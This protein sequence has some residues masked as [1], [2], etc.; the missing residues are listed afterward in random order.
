MGYMQ[1]PRMASSPSE[2]GGLNSAVNNTLA[3]NLGQQY[4]PPEAERALPKL[5]G[6][7]RSP[8]QP[9]QL[10]GEMAAGSGSLA[11]QPQVPAATAKLTAA[12]GSLLGSQHFQLTCL[13]EE[14]LIGDTG[15]SNLKKISSLSQ[16]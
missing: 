3:P 11:P 4:S 13:Y 5:S 12:S 14:L 15:V 6:I 2:T 16:R 8:P 1:G 9:M 7:R 10:G